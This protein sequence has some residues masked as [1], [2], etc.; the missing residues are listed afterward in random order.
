[1]KFNNINEGDV[2]TFN[3]TIFIF[4]CIENTNIICYCSIHK[5]YQNKYELDLTEHIVC[6]TYNDIK[7]ASLKEKAHIIDELVKKHDTIS[8]MYLH[9][10]L[11][12]H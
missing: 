5:K 7:N 2:L 8:M 9:K 4:K 10:Y 11:E 6:S 1:M 12:Q 3:N